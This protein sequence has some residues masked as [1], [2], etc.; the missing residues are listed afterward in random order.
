MTTIQLF[1]ELWMVILVT[2]ITGITMHFVSKCL[3]PE[4]SPETKK[5]EG[6]KD[7]H[8]RTLIS[9]WKDRES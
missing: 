6:F 7:K 2:E 4:D 8:K 1:R 5:L 3:L 9:V